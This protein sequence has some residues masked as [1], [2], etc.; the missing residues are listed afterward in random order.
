[1]GNFHFINCFQEDKPSQLN[2]PN[3]SIMSEGEVLKSILIS[4]GKKAGEIDQFIAEEIRKDRIK[5]NRVGEMT[6]LDLSNNNLTGEI[7]A[8]IGQLIQ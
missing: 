4:L 6:Y 8:S 1:M 5:F 3:K 2:L 7:P